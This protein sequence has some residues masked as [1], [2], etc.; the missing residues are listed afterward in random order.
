MLRNICRTFSRSNKC[1]V[2]I[3][4]FGSFAREKESPGDIDI[5]VVTASTCADVDKL[6]KIIS[7]KVKLP[8]H[9]SVLDVKTLFK[10]TLWKTIIHEG[11]SLLDGKKISE[12]L[13]YKPYVLLW[14]NLSNLK[15]V[16][17]VKFSHA[18]FGRSGR[19]GLLDE[20][21]GVS[22]GKGVLLVP[23]NKEDEIR[24]LFFEWGLPFERRRILVE[25]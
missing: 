8:V 11:I 13:G 10:H 4:L 22:I 24:D 3:I 15:P 23:V 18:L 19:R 7:T 25:E 16:D 9:I 17:K 1:V 6:E 12:K 20:L 5:A 21:G 2:D 14:Y